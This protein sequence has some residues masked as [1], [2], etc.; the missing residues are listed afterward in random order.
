MTAL[1]DRP[2]PAP[3]PPGPVAG[4]GTLLR[5]ALRR[6]RFL[7]PGWTLYFVAISASSYGATV[8]L[9]TD[10]AERAAGAATINA[11]P[12]L[13]ALYGPIYDVTSAGA[14]AFVKLLVFQAALA[15]LVA[16]LLVVRHSRAD[17]ELG[18]RELVA[19]GQVAR[20]AP[21]T[22]AIGAGAFFAVLVGLLS[23]VAAA[24]SGAGVAGSLT[25]GAEWAATGVAFCGVAAVAA[26]LTSSARVARGLV[27]VAIVVTYLVRAVADLTDATWLTWLSPIGWAQQTRPFAE[28][29]LWPL[30]LLLALAAVTTAVAFRIEDRRDLGA[31]V[32]P[33]RAG[34]ARGALANSTALAWRLQRGAL[35]WWA[36]GLGLLGLVV[37]SVVTNLGSLLDTERA[38]TMIELMGGRGVL[39]DAFVSAE[40]GF[41]VVAVTGYALSA[42]SRAHGEETG[43]RLE[44]L[45]ATGTPR[46]TWF[47]GHLVVALLGS[48]LLV[49]VV[50][51]G[52]GTSHA[53]GAGDAGVVADDL[54]AAWVRIPAVWVLLGVGALLYALRPSW[55][56]ASWAV[57]AASV[58]L[59][60]FR[61]LLRLPD[62]VADLSPYTHVPQMPA[63]PFEAGPVLGLLAVAVALLVASV[64]LFE[65]R[66]VAS[67]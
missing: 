13:V 39:E 20:H 52:L 51:L 33:D 17:E 55:F 45:L 48:A 4:A 36:I 19:A 31:G 25:M 5:L 2:S 42:T 47:A 43:G 56:A 14:I 32:L 40:L 16:G 61:E 11:T 64:L 58:V 12:A 67:G 21:L 63:V 59:T 30:L 37:G 8:A 18:R 65:R 53:V 24:A 38:R 46:R 44:G 54:V 7:V 23:G 9:Y 26:Q 66:D 15:A 62:W 35:L 28:N 1:L 60:Q 10:E 34:P 6:D 29:R 49:T 27:V 57:L 3:A 22:A 41:L 50:G